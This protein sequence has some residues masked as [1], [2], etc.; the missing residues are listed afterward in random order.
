MALSDTTIQIGLAAGNIY[1]KDEPAIRELFN[2][3]AWLFWGPS[4]IREKLKSLS[5]TGYS[6]DTATMVTKILLR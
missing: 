2:Q 5:G 1:G 4:E 6:N 3:K